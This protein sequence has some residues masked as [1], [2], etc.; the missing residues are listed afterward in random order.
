MNNLIK[1]AHPIRQSWKQYCTVN[2]TLAQTARVV[3]AGAGL[4]GNSVAYHLTENGWTNVV[5][6]DQRA[7]GSGTSD[8]GSGT[9]GL[10]KPTPERNLIIE[11]LKLYQ[12][13]QQAG[14]N[15]G[16]KKCGALNLAQTHDRVIALKRRIAY[17]LPTGLF[18]EF[19]DA[20]TVKK[21]H[22]LLN[23]DDI[24][25]A[26]YIPDDCI[27]DPA[28]VLL[29]LADISKQRG[30]KFFEGCVVKHVSETYML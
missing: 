15:I 25:G 13:L 24:Q 3:I 10:F 29:A 21:L 9:I 27:A 20:E 6:L 5:V 16:L 11:S 30:V 26:V 18:C 23:V 1:F 19:I 22:P 8:F 17:N 7:I 12:R 4:L 28:L 2:D 14:H